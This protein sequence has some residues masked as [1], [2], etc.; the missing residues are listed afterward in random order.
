[1]AVKKDLDDDIER[2]ADLPGELSGAFRHFIADLGR[3]H[4][5]VTLWKTVVNGSRF[6]RASSAGFRGPREHKPDEHKPACLCFRSSRDDDYVSRYWQDPS[7]LAEA[8]VQG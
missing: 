2:K 3:E 6:W 8:K 1:M 5:P 7:A 4:T